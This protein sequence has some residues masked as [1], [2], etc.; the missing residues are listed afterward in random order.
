MRIINYL[1]QNLWIVIRNKSY[2]G[3]IKGHDYLS[4]TDRKEFTRLISNPDD[5][6]RKKYEDEYAKFIGDGKCLSF[7]AC[8]MAFYTL[9]ICLDV[10]KGDE[11]I[12]T[13]FTC[14]VMVNAIKRVGAIPIYTDIDPETYG[15]SPS[16]IAKKITAKTRVIVAQHSF[17]IPCKIDLIKQ[18]AQNNNL[19]LIEDCALSFTSI[20]KGIK[21]GNWGNAAIFSTDHSKPINTLTGGMLYTLD[22]SLL[23]KAKEI[24]DGSAELSAEHQHRILKQ[25]WLERKY[26]NPKKYAM[27]KLLLVFQIIRN[28]FFKQRITF[29]SDDGYATVK[30]SGA[31]SYPSKMPVFLCRLGLMELTRFGHSRTQRIEFLKKCLH[32]FLENAHGKYIIPQ[33]Y[34]E[35]DNEIVPLRFVFENMDP[36]F[37]NRLSGLIDTSWIWFKQPIVATTEPLSNFGYEAG[38]CPI[39]ELAGTKIINLPCVF[40]DETLLKILWV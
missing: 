22:G 25:I 31:Y 23:A 34:F 27:F 28:K 14:S 39:A 12:L 26:C 6:I 38:T 19:F 20:Y 16:D 13:G 4:L 17:G 3:F 35:K 18:I 8:R 7:A 11:V 5:Q 10:K 2:W 29:L 24:Y 21:L 15:S 9:L 40:D 32:E 33:C 36:N 1:W 37:E 30:S